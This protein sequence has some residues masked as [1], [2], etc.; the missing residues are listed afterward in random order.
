MPI[1]RPYLSKHGGRD[2]LRTSLTPCGNKG[3]YVVHIGKSADFN[4]SFVS[5]R[6]TFRYHKQ[7]E[8]QKHLLM[9]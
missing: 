2:I 8:G 6:K 3:S 4:C 1:T 5:V 7:L 9:T